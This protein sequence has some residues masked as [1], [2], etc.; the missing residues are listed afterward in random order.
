MYTCMCCGRE[1]TDNDY[2]LAIHRECT[3]EWKDRKAN[4]RCIFCNKKLDK[5]GH[6]KMDCTGIT[7]RGY[8]GSIL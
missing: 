6:P 4:M 7:Y 5:D 1:L 3:N 8:P 2:G